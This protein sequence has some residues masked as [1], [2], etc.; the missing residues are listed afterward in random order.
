MTRHA[1][2]FLKSNSILLQGK[3]EQGDTDEKP[4]KV[5]KKL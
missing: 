3:N 1:R 2:R 5:F 4:Y